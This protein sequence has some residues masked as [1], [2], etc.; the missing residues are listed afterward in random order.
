MTEP[1]G[2]TPLPVEKNMDGHGG[3]DPMSLLLA[4]Y[5]AML[6][7]PV[8]WPLLKPLMKIIHRKQELMT[9]PPELVELAEV[10]KRIV[11]QE[12]E[13]CVLSEDGSR[14]FGCYASQEEAM[15]RLAQIE[16][17][18]AKNLTGR[19]TADLVELAGKLDLT[20]LDGANDL[21]ELV[22]SEL[23]KRASMVARVCKADDERR[24][25]LGPV[26]VP[27]SLDAHGDFTDADTLQKALW[28]WMRRGDRK[29]ML[30][31]S[32]KPAGE[33]VEI[34][35][36]PWAMTTKMLLPGGEPT[37]A[38]FP[39]DT[40]F[41]GVIWEDWAWDLVKAGELRGYSIGGRARRVEADFAS[42]S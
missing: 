24:Y 19:T 28:E 6:E 30:Q 32:E 1:S 34:L 16:T 26:Y 23:T 7:Y 20:D 15:E 13:Y 41:M 5:R 27:G 2:G 22:E 8:C 18:A 33:M 10:D 4:A 14:N 31:H 12:G 37:E 36:W 38:T 9:V 3:S 40:P 35:T 17:F 39:A 29:I 11:T 25:T 42:E 21:R